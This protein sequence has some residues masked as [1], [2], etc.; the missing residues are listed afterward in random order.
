MVSLAKG[1]FYS[2]VKDNTG[3]VKLVSLKISYIC[4]QFEQ[5]CFLLG[6][7]NNLILSLSQGKNEYLQ[8]PIILSSIRKGI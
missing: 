7:I 8:R 6:V 3:I 2:K 5:R 4:P 1:F